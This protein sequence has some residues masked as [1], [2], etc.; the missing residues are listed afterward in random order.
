MIP[1]ACGSCWL[2]A[3]TAFRASRR[4]GA[5]TLRPDVLDGPA[6]AAAVPA[7][8][9][10]VADEPI[11]IVGMSC[12]FPGGAHDPESLWELLVAGSD[13]ISGFPQDR[14]W[15]VE[16]L[17]D[18]DPDPDPDPGA[19]S[20]PREGG[21]VHD[22]AD[23]DPG[24]F[25]ISPREA[26]AMDPQQRLLLEVSWEALE[27]A[28]IDPRSL[29]GSKTGVFI[30]GYSSGYG[31]VV[32]LADEGRGE[33]EGHLVTGSSTSVM[34]GRVAYALGLEGPAVTVDTADRKST[35]LN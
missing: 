22:A 19:A 9:V 13:G 15:D 2:R 20:Y 17:Y 3:A 4:T 26:L 24:F 28:G 12:R 7:T 8:A 23:F 1:K 33:L 6:A 14:G 10:P 5:G 16:A 18:P 27:R 11:A 21:F 31:L 25:G 30:G 32:Q 34:S 35:R 29:Q